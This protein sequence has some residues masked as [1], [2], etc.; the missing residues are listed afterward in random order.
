MNKAFLGL[1][2]ALLSSTALAQGSGT[3]PLGTIPSG[4]GPGKSGW[5]ASGLVSVAAFTRGG[6]SNDTSGVQAAFTACEAAGG[7]VLLCGT[8]ATYTV[9]T[10]NVSSNTYSY[11]ECTFNQRTQGTPIFLGTGVSNVRLSQFKLVGKLASGS[12]LLVPVSGDRA[13]KFV[14]N[15]NNIW[16][17]HL[18]IT[19]FGQYAM[20]IEQSTN[21]DIQS[22]YVF[23]NAF[24]V[25]FR[26][27][28]QGV[29]ANNRFNHTA[30][31][32]LNP[33]DTQLV[34]AIAL[35]STDQNP[36]GISTDIV[37]SGNN[38]KDFPLSQAIFAHAGIRITVANNICDSV[39]RCISFNSYNT[40]DT[41]SSVTMTG[42][43]GEGTSALTLPVNAAFDTGIV[44]AGGA[45]TS[46][47][48]PNIGTVAGGSGYVDGIFFGVPM[49]GGTGTG[50]TATITV[51]GGSVKS[52]ANLGVLPNANGSGYLV[53]DVLSASLS[54]GSGFTYT[55]T[56]V[57][58]GLTPIILDSSVVGNSMHA[59]NRIVLDPGGGC[60]YIGSTNNT[61]VSGNIANACGVNGYVFVA[62]ETGSTVTGNSCNSP[63][64]SAATQN[65]YL[66]AGT[67]RATMMGNMASGANN[68]V[69]TG[70]RV[71]NDTFL[72]WKDSGS[73]LLNG[74]FDNTTASVP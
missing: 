30:M 45:C 64:V 33:I 62:E 53:G 68:A 73:V 12:G 49:T 23:E 71:A 65:C 39:S 27:V 35:E 34:S 57:T 54:G 47:S 20:Y 29:V 26:G 69:G 25:W 31:Y 32:S 72:K 38:I 21:I 15:S 37:I 58:G 17:D 59:F 70:Y 14:A 18:Y 67:P 19:R 28:S 56:S 46:G 61:T 74:S 6:T 44:L 1:T 42:N 24:G 36:Y 63:R 41:I 16:L 50:L 11:G 43:I 9:D 55:L 13:I 8:G 52:F 2:F 22:N 7:C 51:S 10:I 3:I 48:C 5:G 66:W 4:L 40:T 60:F